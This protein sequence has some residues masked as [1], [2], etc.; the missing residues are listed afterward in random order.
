MSC[1]SPGRC[2]TG[3]CSSTGGAS[4]RKAR[5]SRCCEPPRAAHQGLRDR[6]RL[7]FRGRARGG[8]ARD[9]VEGR[10]GPDRAARHGGRTERRRAGRGG[11]RGRGGARRCPLP[12][13]GGRPGRGRRPRGGGLRRLVGQRRLGLCSATRRRSLRRASSPTRCARSA[14]RPRRCTCDPRSTLRWP[15]GRCASGAAA[16]G[17]SSR[18]GTRRSRSSTAAR[19]SSSM[20]CGRRAWRRRCAHPAS[21]TRSCRR[22]PPAATLRSSA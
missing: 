14:G 5:R 12:R 19:S 9:G 8:R 17:R 4:S 3:W 22:M 2:P 10:L 11:R 7:P 18:A 20:R 15:A 13:G 21:C 6:L 1:P 16:A